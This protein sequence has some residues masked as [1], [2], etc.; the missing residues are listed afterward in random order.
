M[1]ILWVVGIVAGVV[2]LIVLLRLA[3][4]GV[5][6]TMPEAQTFTPAPVMRSA[7]PHATNATPAGI[8]P[9][10][11]AEIDR[12]VAAGRRVPAIKVLRQHA[13]ISL[14]EA[15]DRIDHWSISTTAPHGPAASHATPARTTTSAEPARRATAPA[16]GSVRASLPPSI[17]V[18]IDNLISAGQPVRAIKLLRDRT[19]LG[20][21]D[22][23]REID[24]W[25]SGR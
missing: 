9:Q 14:R 6:P 12:L 19:G 15:K 13:K 18:E 8:S 5:R 23:K 7:P 10:V 24:A 4:R 3:F 2:A 21:K 16:A 11:I 25:R 20:L 1:E 17:V 22:A